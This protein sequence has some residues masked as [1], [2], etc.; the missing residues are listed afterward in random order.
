MERVNALF[1]KFKE[2]AQ[3]KA[4]PRPLR[5]VG[6]VLKWVIPLAYVI[7]ILYDPTDKVSWFKTGGMAVIVLFI[8]IYFFRWKKKMHDAMIIEKSA[9]K[10]VFAKMNSI[11]LSL[12]YIIDSVIKIG[13]LGI[14]YWL[15]WEIYQ[16][17]QFTL[18]LL[19][20][21]MWCEIIGHGLCLI[22]FFLNI[23]QEQLDEEATRL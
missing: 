17:S 20:V 4:R 13:T 1:R 15:M 18:V 8:I 6:F 10:L 3:K 19:N 14:V 22:D 16:A 5:V 7:F 9:E 23:G 21:L 12:F 2:D 11:K